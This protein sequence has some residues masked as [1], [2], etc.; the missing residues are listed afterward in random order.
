MKLTLVA[1]AMVTL[2]F[3]G[4]AVQAQDSVPLVNDGKPVASIY[5]SDEKATP[6]EKWAAEELV[7]HIKKM[8]GAELTTAAQPGQAPLTRI[9]IG[10]DAVKTVNSAASIE[11]LGP[12]GFIIEVVKSP[13]GSGGDVYLYGTQPRGTLYAVYTMLE[14]LGVRWWTP[15]ETYIP[16]LKTVAVPVGRSEETPRLEYRDM[17]YL[18]SIN[19]EGKL[20]FARNKLN[21]FAWNE[22]PQALMEKLG[23]RYRFHG[24]LVHAYGNLLRASG[25]TMEDAMRAQVNGKPNSGQPCLSHPKVLEAIT[26]QVIK[27]YKADPQ[28]RF[29][30]VGQDDNNN[31][32]R[33]EKCQAVIDAEGA[34]GPVIQFANQVAERV[35]KEVPGAIITTAAYSWSRQPP[36]TI[37]PRH[38]VYITLCTIECDFAHSLAEGTT[39]INRAF[40]ED[41]QAWSKMTNKLLIWDYV[42]NYWRFIMPHPNLDV[43]VPNVKFFA[44][45]GAAGVF[46]QAAHTG[47]GSDLVGLRMWVL[48]KG[49]WNP[50]A[51][52]W[53]LINEFVDGYYGPAAPSIKKYLEIIHKPVRERPDYVMR[54]YRDMNA[55]YLTPAVM[56]DAAV[57]LV[58]AGNAVEGDQ[59][60]ERRVRHAHM[61]LWYVLAMR[62]PDSKMWKAVEAKVGKIDPVGFANDFARMANESGVTMV[63]DGNT[64]DPWLQ[65]L[66]DYMTA[67]AKSGAPLP[68]E[69]DGRDP[70]TYRLIQASQ[71]DRMARWL[72]KAEGASD[73]WALRC[74][75]IAWVL[76]H[77]LDEAID[78]EPGKTYRLMARVKGQPKP[79]ASGRVIS[80]GMSTTVDGRAK[81][82]SLNPTAE[83]MSG[84]WQVIEII[85]WKP[86]H[87]DSYW[88]AL[89]NPQAMGEVLQ[90]CMWLELV[91]EE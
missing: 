45:M 74:P 21:G 80:A 55:P 88:L 63:A 49:L 72:V 61:G 13:D 22:R 17:M 19:E 23:G 67:V 12:D 78:F 54:I 10:L 43:L 48:A 90:D 16:E 69:L 26:A 30:V 89:G 60:L 91:D 4:A 73:G 85:K 6:S 83:T 5:I 8:S 41:I 11:K 79:E 40:R 31:Y 77:G 15:T 35:E 75:T 71:M 28:L 1:V 38:N 29:V 46:E 64:I 62:G 56:A 7:S 39:D 50:D 14:S 42:T 87:G 3:S 33:C 34:S 86:Q 84:D 51:D 65:W 52:N 9:F 25:V 2:L 32:C 70:S 20:W 57:A 82:I 37:R 66:K 59:V 36:K 76:R 27:I 47:G 81:H 58:E 68:P 53:G 24:N 44:D 18:E